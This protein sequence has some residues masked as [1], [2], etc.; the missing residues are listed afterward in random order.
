MV[1]ARL[2]CVLI[3]YLRVQELGEGVVDEAV[4]SSGN[5]SLRL[6]AS[7]DVVSIL[8]GAVGDFL[9]DF[10]LDVVWL[11]VAIDELAVVIGRCMSGVSLHLFY[12]V[13]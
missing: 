12:S 1:E 2:I 11:V 13:N 6:V 9:V 8:F 4:T 5:L 7:V 10:K 3:S